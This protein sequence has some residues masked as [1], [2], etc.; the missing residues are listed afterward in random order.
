[1]W[2]ARMRKMYGFKGIHDSIS[3]SHGDIARNIREY[4][5]FAETYCSWILGW[6]NVNLRGSMIIFTC[7][8]NVTWEGLVKGLPP[9]WYRDIISDYNYLLWSGMTWSI[10][11]TKRI[12]ESTQRKHQLHQHNDDY[13]ISSYLFTCSVPI[14]LQPFYA[15]NFN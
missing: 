2:D 7:H 9:D 8:A 6:Y 1:M 11:Q 4:F 15:M 3:T 12:W 10:L 14:K 13:C 5:A